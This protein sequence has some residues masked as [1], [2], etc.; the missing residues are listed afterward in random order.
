MHWVFQQRICNC[1]I[2]HWYITLKSNDS[3]Q[4]LSSDHNNKLQTGTVSLLLYGPYGS[5]T[6]IRR[7]I[8]YWTCKVVNRPV[9]WADPI[10]TSLTGLKTEQIKIWS[11]LIPSQAIGICHSLCISFLKMPSPANL[12][13][14]RLVVWRQQ[15][16]PTKI[17]MR[18]KC[19]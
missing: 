14:H 9:Q 4:G 6:I 3:N 1:S 18:A 19:C 17:Y 12:C 11:C 15:S 7:S 10:K 5:P 16:I 2:V 13:P 8:H